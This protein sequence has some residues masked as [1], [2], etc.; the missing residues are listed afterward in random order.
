MLSAAIAFV[1]AINVLC[2]ALLAVPSRARR[3]LPIAQAK[4]IASARR[5][6]K[7]RR[8]T[9]GARREGRTLA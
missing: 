4:L 2:F 3:A 6:D 1:F 8:L 5:I 9:S 7:A